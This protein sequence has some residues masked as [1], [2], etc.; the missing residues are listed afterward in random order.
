M[1]NDSNI[2]W[3]VATD[4]LTGDSKQ[5]QY[6][7]SS[8]K[9]ESCCCAAVPHGAELVCR[10]LHGEYS[11]LP[12]TR[13]AVMC[14][15]VLGQ[16]TVDS[17]LK[18]RDAKLQEA[19]DLHRFLRSVDHFQAWFIKTQTDVA[20]EDIP[21][22]LTEAEK[23]LSQHQTIKEEIDNY[24]DEYAKMMEYGEKITANE[25]YIKAMRSLQE[26]F[27]SQPLT[28]GSTGKEMISFP[29]IK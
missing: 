19:G 7:E 15:T 18:E 2:S 14:P 25:L 29:K 10:R 28:R 23:L 24:K 27:P 8:V 20:L 11:L 13:I 12:V 21:C 16:C 4:D 6:C 26:G 22:S 1:D 17:A 5:P 3:L 9:G